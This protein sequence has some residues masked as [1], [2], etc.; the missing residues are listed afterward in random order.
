MEGLRLCD[1]CSLHTTITFSPLPNSSNGI[2]QYQELDK[3]AG[4][5]L[6]VRFLYF[7]A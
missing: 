5:N 4:F 2:P 1:A 7:V 3:K 6:S